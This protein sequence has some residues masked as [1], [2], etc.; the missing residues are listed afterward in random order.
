[1]IKDDVFNLIKLSMWGI[2][3][4]KA[5][6]DTYEEMKRHSL[7]ALPA[8]VLSSVIM[9]DQLRQTWKTS[10]L[11]Q[12]AQYANYLCQQSQLPISIPY[13][14][15]KGTSAAKYYPYPEYRCMGDI[16][17]ITKREDYNTACNML[18]NNGW[19]EMTNHED[20]RGRHRI[21]CNKL[22]T[23]EVHA[24]FASMNNIQ[25]AKALDDLIIQNITPSHIL[26]DMINGLV[27]LDHINQHLEGGL[28]LR[29]IID[30]MMFAEKCLPDT[31]W[32]SFQSL[33]AKTGLEKLA[34]IVTRMCEIY[35]GLPE[36][37]WSSKANVKTCAELMD[38]VFSCGNFNK[39]VDQADQLSINRAIKLR[40]P[41]KLIRDL[42]HIGCATWSAANN[43]VVRPFAWIWQGIQMKKDTPKLYLQYSRAR[44]L[45]KLFDKLGVKRARKG[46]VY[47]EDGKYY[48]K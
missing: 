4:A 41:I 20:V 34:I 43:P 32:S 10:I 16:D 31:Q 8:A 42:Q 38:Y 3:E 2:G 44:R 37:K 1:M 33:A 11:E 40:H 35:L 24:F 17:V 23:V 7:L 15:L 30:W 12:M 13:V 39:G 14:I 28:G 47:Y 46:L 9:P 18:I 26:P 25:K 45:D 5:C 22:I 36:R 19:Y 21:F 27:L 6:L 48:K 29:Q